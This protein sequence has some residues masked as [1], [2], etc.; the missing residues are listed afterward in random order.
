MRISSRFYT[1][2]LTARRPEDAVSSSIT[3][4]ATYRQVPTLSRGLPALLHLHLLSPT[5]AHHLR[6]RHLFNLRLSSTDISS[7]S[8]YRQR[9]DVPARRGTRGRHS[10]RG[11][12]EE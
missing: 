7:R 6:S 12:V 10:P 5:L 3:T 9:N 4:T 8:S 11:S 2:L 1:S